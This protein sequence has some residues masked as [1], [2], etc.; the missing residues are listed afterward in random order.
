MYGQTVKEIRKMKGYTQKEVYAGIVSKSFYSD[1]EKEKYSISIEK[2]EG[3]LRNLAISFEEFFYF[4]Y[5]MNVSDSKQ[6][7]REI[8]NAYKTGD[9]ETLFSIY[10][11]NYSS[12]NKE[13]RYLAT[14]AY[15]LV[16]ITNSNFYKF[17][18]E[19][20]NEI[21]VSLENTKTWT[22]HELTLAKLVLLSLS[23]KEADRAS[24]LFEKIK[25]EL[26]K[27][28][29]FEN[30]LYEKELTDLF[31]NRIQSLLII[32][33]LKDAEIVLEEYSKVAYQADD[34]TLFIQF[35]FMNIL[36]GLYNDYPKF[37]KEVQL[38]FKQI[39]EIP[40]SEC[41]FYKII[42][43]IHN[44]KAKNYYTRYSTRK[45]LD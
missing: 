6:L 26:E 2:F 13:C 17:S 44:E 34:I 40:V 41:H 30:K 20:F 8:D 18:R 15:L 43:Q 7:E 5:Q 27:Y 22:I 23:E 37:E 11:Q 24:T 36:L 29:K 12:F 32:N 33:K 28:V 21:V 1:F 16:L 39:E 4:Y 9:F 10:Q 42:F 25:V 19:P 14:K 3:L 45:K 35:K 31:F 38:F